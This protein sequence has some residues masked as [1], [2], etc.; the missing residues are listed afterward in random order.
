[1]IKIPKKMNV[2]FIIT[3]AQRANYLSCTGNPTLK[4]PNI[5]SIGEEGVIFTNC[6]ST[7][8]FCMP[9]RA[10]IFTGKYPNVH[11]VRSNGIHLPLDVPTI[12]ESL[13]KR[14]WHTHSIGKLHFQNTLPAKTKKYKSEENVLAWLYE[15]DYDN[16]IKNFPS[17][18]YGFEDVEI[19]LGQGDLCMGHYIPW[20]EERAP[21]YADYIREN[22]AK[23]VEQLYY[24]TPIP[25]ELYQTTYIKERTIKF[26]EDYAQG[27]HG[28]KPFFLNCSFPD[29]HPPSSPPGKYKDLYKP[30][31]V[32]LPI[33]FNNLENLYDHPFMGEYLKNPIYKT[34]IRTTTE[35]EARNFIALSYGVISMIDDA[36]G[37]ILASLEEQGLAEN[38]MVIYT[39]DHGYLRGEHGL[40]LMGP[41]PFSAMLNVPLLWRVPGLTKS[42]TSSSLVSSI[43]IPKTILNL[44]GIPERRQPEGMQGVDI[45]P[46]LKDST[47]KVRDCCII[48]ED[49]E[50]GP[51]K[52][53]VRHLV[54]ETHK[55]TLYEGLEDFGDLYNR[56]DDPEELNNLWFDDSIKDLRCKLVNK[57]FQEYMK[58]QSRYPERMA[59]T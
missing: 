22:L 38:T 47:E 8:P 30:E 39:S 52:V 42:G 51:F 29:P 24:D 15:K 5:D 54:T 44:L 32:V 12:L 26:L 37:E 4:T 57:L 28:D 49:E 45:T 18:Y 17:P 2:L 40:V 34:I 58:I 20:L 33:S 31:E 50:M 35:E 36:V 9:S 13:S 14:G 48:E 41:C 6:F 10:T 7:N 53:R 19:T 27:E 56:K 55:L 11:G 21:Q 25:E 59:P 46:V 43:D 16:R 1:V 3:D 23:S